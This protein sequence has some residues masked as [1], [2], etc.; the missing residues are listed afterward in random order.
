MMRILALTALVLMALP[1]VAFAANMTVYAPEMKVARKRGL[2]ELT[3]P[4]GLRAT[5]PGYTVKAAHGVVLLRSEGS[6]ELPDMPQ[7]ND[8]GN[9]PK[10]PDASLSLQ[11]IKQLTFTGSA[12]WDSKEYR[13]KAGSASSSDGGKTW[14]LSGGVK[15]ARKDSLQSARGKSFTFSLANST[16][17]T[18]T[19]IELFGFAVGEENASFSSKNTVINLK[20]RSATLTGDAKFEFAD[21]S[22]VSAKMSIDLKA[23][24]LVADG[25]PKLVSGDSI[26]EAK[27]VTITFVEGRAVLDAVDLKGRLAAPKGLQP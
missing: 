9:V 16:L 2:V 4:A 6:K 18:S 10:L 19:P 17:S 25:S 1:A 27:Q 3:F 14:Q 5:A 26:I 11:N 21:Y 13:A 15:F 23:Q 12:V 20:T 7:G 24:K 8:G 22:L